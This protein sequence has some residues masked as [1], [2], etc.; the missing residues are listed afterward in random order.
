MDYEDEE[1]AALRS[2][3]IATAPQISSVKYGL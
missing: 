1:D 3:F 2:L